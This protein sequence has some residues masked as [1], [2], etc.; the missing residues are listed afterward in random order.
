MKKALSLVLAVC[1]ML[2]VCSPVV[3]EEKTTLRVSW[4]GGESRHAATIAALNLFMQKY[5]QFE[6]EGEYNYCFLRDNPAEQ[7]LFYYLRET[8]IKAIASDECE[9]N[10]QEIRHYFDYWYTMHD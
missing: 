9:L 8:L 2:L 3:A 6:V 10:N 7:I 1:L 5:P 4:W